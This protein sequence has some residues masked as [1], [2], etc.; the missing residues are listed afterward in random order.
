MGQNSSKGLALLA[1][2]NYFYLPRRRKKVSKMQ[3]KLCR[4]LLFK[5]MVMTNQIKI[6]AVVVIKRAVAKNH[7]RDILKMFVAVLELLLF[8]C[9]VGLAF[10]AGKQ[11][12]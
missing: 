9:A 11:E 2:E 12:S 7:A 3:R 6:S 10:A 5:R 1:T 4:R 8:I